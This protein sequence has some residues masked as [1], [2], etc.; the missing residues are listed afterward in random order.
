MNIANTMCA[1]SNANLDWHSINWKQ[2]QNNV[3]KQQLRIAKAVNE[4]RWNKA[5]ALQRLL[6]SSF[7]AKALAVR[8]VTENRGKKTAGIDG[9]LWSTPK[10]KFE[11]IPK[12]R[13]HGYKPKP[14]RRIY[15]PKNNSRKEYRPLSIPCMIDRAMQSL[16]LL[17]LEPIAET[18]A[19]KNSYGFRPLRSPADAIEQ[20]FQI[21]CRAKSA[22]YILEADIK[23]C[24]D[25]ISHPWLETNIP[26][27]KGILKQWL[28]V[29]FMDKSTLHMTEAGVPQGSP[30]SPAITNMTLDGLEVLLAQNFSLKIKQ[31]KRFHPKV[32]LVR[33]ADDFVVTG[34]SIDVLLEVK[35]V[36]EQFLQERGLELSATKTRITHINDGF[37]FLGQNIR[38]FKGKLLIQ[39]AKKSVQSF[40][41]KLRNLIHHHRQSSQVDLIKTLNPVIK[42]WANYHRHSCASRCFA[43]LD[44][45]IWQMLWHWAKRRHSRKSAQWV[46]NR[47][48]LDL[49]QR[50]VFACRVKD[51]VPKSGY[52]FYRLTKAITINIQ[53]HIKIKANAN[54]F[55]LSSEIYFEQRLRKKM[56]SQLKGRTK[57]L[58]I[59][60]RQQG[61]CL[62]CQHSIN[63]QTGWHLHHLLPKAKGG[64]N[65]LV[66]LVMLHP[67]CHYQVHN[68]LDLS[69]RLLA[70][71]KEGL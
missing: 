58:T 17:A 61:I 56:L 51:E 10:A 11:A 35:L 70:L 6:T 33:F 28:N 57:L 4:G 69:N 52:R 36:I 59:W 1:P 48:F 60:K 55:D 42:G 39:P 46:K 66:N 18:T 3:K 29:G 53:R 47:Y 26:M 45:R 20:C 43:K 34:S 23:A 54:P 50:W 13:R 9:E 37:D 8:R 49:E 64:S 68:N 30:I 16:H 12:L 38:K 63:K 14:L 65:S 5:K 41:A 44:H 25:T 21:L 15:I 62:N 32:N 7:S 67:T 19:D 2:V 27:D 40:I 22:Q 71:T 24:F 31:G